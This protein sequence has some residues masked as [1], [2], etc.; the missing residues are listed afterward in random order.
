M[1]IKSVKMRINDQLWIECSNVKGPLYI[2]K[3]NASMYEHGIHH[4]HV[5]AIDELDRE[6]E[7]VQPF[8]L[9][10]TRL[11]FRILPRFI[12]MSDATT[13]VS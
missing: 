13:I 8:A 3:W 11:S 10:G 1:P 5:K 4:I 12:L 6:K 9:D 7:V 2:A